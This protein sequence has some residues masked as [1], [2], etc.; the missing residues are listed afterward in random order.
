MFVVSPLAVSAQSNAELQTM[1]TALLQQIASLQQQLAQLQGGGTTGQVCRT[2]NTDLTIG[3]SG[4][5]V[6]ALNQLLR[7]E[8]F[9][10]DDMDTYFNEGTAG[11]VV[12]FQAKYGIRQTGY[13][14]P[15][16]RAKINALYRC[17]NTT[18]PPTPIPPYVSASELVTCTFLGSTTQQ[19]CSPVNYDKRTDAPNCTG[20]GYC[21]SDVRGPVNSVIT[22]GSSCPSY[23]GNT[24][25]T[26]DGRN[27]KVIFNC[28]QAT[29]TSIQVLSPNGGETIQEGTQYTIRWS[30]AN[31][32]P[33]ATFSVSVFNGTQ[34]NALDPN[35]TVVSNLPAGTNS[36]TWTVASNHNWGMGLESRSQKLARFLGIPTAFAFT[37]QY[38]VGVRADINGKEIAFDSSNA[39]FT[40]TPNST[41]NLPPVI[42]SV[43]APTTLNIGQVGRWTVNATDP[44]NGYLNYSIDWGDNNPNIYPFA[45]TPIQM[46]QTSTFTHSYS[47]S[48]TFTVKI[49]VLD[50]TGASAQTSSTVVVGQNVGQ[51]SLS[52]LFPNGVYPGGTVTLLG[53]N[54]DQRTLVVLD[55]MTYSP[56]SPDHVSSDG[57]VLGLRVPLST[58]AGIHTVQVAKTG[59]LNSLSNQLMLSVVTTQ[60]QPN[61]TSISPSSATYG[62]TVTLNGSGFTAASV[63]NFSQNG[64]SAGS[65]WGTS[66][67]SVSN[68]QI[69]FTLALNTS[70]PTGVY[71]VTVSN[72]DCST[73]CASNMVSNA[74]NLTLVGQVT[75]PP[76]ILPLPPTPPTISGT[77]TVPTYSG[78]STVQVGT[79]ANY[80]FSSTD[81]DSTGYNGGL[82]T[83][84]INWGDNNPTTMSSGLSSGAVFSA[85][86]GWQSVGT[87][88][89]TITATPALGTPAYKTFT[90]TVTPPPPTPITPP[91]PPPPTTYS[92]TSIAVVSPNGGETWT[93]GTNP[94]VTWMGGT[95]ASTVNISIADQ[96]GVGEYLIAQNV[97]NTGSYTFSAWTDV[98]GGSFPNSSYKVKIYKYMSTYPSYYIIGNGAAPFTITGSV[99]TADQNIANTLSAI[100]ALLQSMGQTLR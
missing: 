62:Q 8:G 29:P 84:T 17:G 45:P 64:V 66:I 68:N 22:W 77:P 59:N 67:Q 32:P 27:E 90:V 43:T 87:Y 89:V 44:E 24:T 5:D 1:I 41:G 54:F 78:F 76:P 63:I 21:Q 47:G 74:V 18:T 86:H 55:G 28:G 12:S 85:S 39:S 88:T 69:V 13:F 93:R 80:T 97:P 79:V 38:K 73:S 6:F 31:M 100:Q 57:T 10:F 4:S 51:A 91:T 53:N 16:T 20:V 83:Y 98:Y 70:S 34:G 26:L 15:L 2:F 96:N 94:T 37:N 95:N 81:Q 49:T 46:S 61:I 9:E 72:G 11:A 58:T 3:S 48:G 36:Y 75:L 25:T 56:I 23:D 50:S 65:L 99:V 33:D 19:K 82:I 40:I 7:K 52:S 42:N 60:V 92:A 14:G 30:T 71:Q 35:T